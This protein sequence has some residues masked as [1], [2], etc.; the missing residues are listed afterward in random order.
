MSDIKDNKI[1]SEENERRIIKLCKEDINRIAAGEVIIRPCN[2]L[3]E[4][5]E[6]SL[7]ANSTN[8]S[9]QLNK[10]G[11][12][13][14]Q[15]IDDGDGI[16][17]DDLYIVC[18]RFTTSKISSHKDIRS[19]KTFG[20]RGEA[21]ASISHV[22]YLTITTK[23]RK[24]SSC[25]T[26]SYKD[27]KPTQKE[28]TACSG[29]DGT[30]IRFDDLFYNMKT[31][32]KTLNHND[33]Y[34]KCLDVL[35]KYSIHYP[36]VTFTC[37]KWLS[38]VVDLSTYNAGKGIGGIGGIYLIK[39][40]RKE[41]FNDVIS[42]L[43]TGETGQE[44]E[45]NCQENDQNDQ[46][47]L[48]KTNEKGYCEFE[49]KILEEEKELD[50]NYEKYLNNTKTIIQKIYGRSVSKELIPIFV[51]EKIPTFF[52]CYGLISGPSY[53]SKKSSYI[54]FINDRLVES[55]IL[56][57][58]CE[59]QYNNFLGKG[60]YPWVYLALRLK[61]DIVDINVHP[62]KKEVH[63]LY[64]DEI[65]TL[66]SKK[67][68][69]VLKNI[70]NMRSYNAPTV[71]LLQTKFDLNTGKIDIKKEKQTGSN[72]YSTGY[73]NGYSN[74]HSNSHIDGQ[75]GSDNK[76]GVKKAIDTKRVRT[77]YKQ[78]TLTNYFV[79]KSDDNKKEIT[80]FEDN[81]YETFQLEAPKPALYNVSQ[82]KHISNICYDRKLPSE[83]DEITSIK[84]LRKIC[85]EK[86]K[87]ELT[88]CLK[89]SIYVGPVDNMHSLI[90]Y[91]EK[92]LMIK[93][94][95]IIK[96][97]I[98]QSILNRIG[99]IPPFKFDPPI[100]LYDLLLVG[101]NNSYS[102]FFENPNY[103]NKNI[104]IVCNE[105][106]QVFYSYEEMYADYFSIVI[107]DGH[108]V[109]FPACCGEYFPGQEFLPLLFLRLAIQIDYENE[110]N[111]INGICYLLANF[112]SKITLTSDTEWTY[113]DELKMIKERQVEMLLNQK[114]E[115][116][117]KNNKNDNENDNE[118]EQNYDINFDSILGDETVIDVNKH[119]PVSKNINLVF[120]QY[121][122]P[123]IQLNNSM[124]IPNIFSTNGY[125]I[126][127][128]SLNQLYKIFERC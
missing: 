97:I 2:A 3:K 20:F 26:C 33:E 90:Q 107:E 128:T 34:N 44:N 9:V 38:N 10:G 67:I 59:N 89:N 125:I 61:Y 56:K 8:I 42:G 103:A 99:K 96:E 12:K 82:D 40:K 122:F 119:L 27:G 16:H 74:S 105:L 108:I 14:V 69:Q 37:K 116:N 78:I 60:N 1:N 48:I 64:Q 88:E 5:V 23:K 100:P 106:E 55:N 6:N 39:N 43:Q 101:L 17:K 83:C 121:F 76:S 94:P 120:E 79:K 66:I 15:I 71:N 75:R 45:Q 102:G 117:S 126:E 65:A 109:T 29:K 63:F 47:N 62:T 19:I 49:R 51:N 110:I 24:S 11:L 18:E 81:E 30:I 86:E 80:L 91:K 36:H 28:P 68:E 124:K 104:E 57:R 58:A 73:S 70:N 98:Y 72:G 114:K 46:N 115:K 54:F 7:D 87:K 31:R 21:L 53:N 13:S 25:Y 35:Q 123:M 113:H 127:L 22:S 95:L 93:M 52:K 84:K 92:L 41:N 50:K 4:L 112:Y 32:L 111:C 85:E 77:D 118:N